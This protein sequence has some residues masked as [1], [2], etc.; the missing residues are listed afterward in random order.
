MPRRWRIALLREL[1]WPEFT[2]TREWVVS[3][4]MMVSGIRVVQIPLE[5]TPASEAAARL[6]LGL[7]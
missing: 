7:S 3:D 4:R 2:V 6:H 5:D 1:A